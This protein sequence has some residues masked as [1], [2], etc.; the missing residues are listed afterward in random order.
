MHAEGCDFDI[1]KACLALRFTLHLQRAEGPTR[2]GGFGIAIC[3][4]RASQH[5][6]I[7][8][9]DYPPD[10]LDQFG[11]REGLVA[12][13]P[14]H[15][16]RF[17]NLKSDGHDGVS[18]PDLPLA[19]AHEFLLQCLAGMA[20]SSPCCQI[21]RA[22]PAKAS[23]GAIAGDPGV[24]QGLAILCPYGS[25]AAALPAAP[26][27]DE[28]PELSRATADGWCCSSLL[29]FYAGFMGLNAFSPLTMKWTPFGG[30]IPRFFTP[31][32]IVARCAGASL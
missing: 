31:G 5:C 11:Q 17:A 3:L 30:R 13:Q 27:D 12:E 7:T 20:S 14:H 19:S 6:F 26:H 8:T 18:G 29:T 16:C 25:T 1:E 21:N 32:L 10:A 9:R 28:H 2:P 22:S 15:A 23:R 4:P 24:L